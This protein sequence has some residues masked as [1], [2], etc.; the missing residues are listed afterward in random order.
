MRSRWALTWLLVVGL[1]PLAHGLEWSGIRDGALHLKP[2][3][4]EPLQ[5][6]WEP[7]WQ[8]D[9]NEE[10]L[11]L[12]DSTGKLLQ[13]FDIPAHEQRGTRRW[14]LH[15]ASSGYRLEIPGYSFRLYQIRHGDKTASLFEPV[16]THFSMEAGRDQTLYFR[17]PAGVSVQLGGKHHGGVHALTAER[18]SDKHQVHL[19]LQRHALYPRSDL[20]NLPVS[21]QEQIWRLRLLG[22]GKAAFWL[23]GTDNLF[24]QRPEHLYQPSQPPGRVGLALHNKVLGPTAKL[25][26]ALP[27]SLPEDATLLGTLRPQAAGHYSF[28]N[29]MARNP[30]H[31]QRFRPLFRHKYGIAN[32]ITLLAKTGRVADLDFDATSRAGLQ[33]WLD[34]TSRLGAG[35]T[36][37]LSMADEPN[38]NYS[39][40]SRF[41][42]Y[43]RAMA[44][45]VRAHP[46]AHA[47]GIRI[48]IPASSRLVNGPTM[49]DSRNRRGIDW[50]KRLLDEH[51]PL[52]DALAWHEWMV[53]DLRATDWYRYSVRQAADLVGLDEQGRPRKALLID[54]TNLSS[55]NTISHYEQDTQFAALWWASVAIQSS[56]DGLLD[57]LNWFLL[58][59]DDGHFKGM[60]RLDATG[61]YS[62]RPVGHAMNFMQRYWGDDVLLLDNDAFEV[63]ALASRSGKQLNLLG[64]NKVDRLQRVRFTHPNV[65][66]SGLDPPRLNLFSAI[67][68]VPG[69]VNCVSGAWQF[70]VPAESLFALTWEQP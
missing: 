59:D 46:D 2:A 35:G 69:A 13:R 28:V 27:Y 39:S 45:R 31:E 19:Q 25:G 40:Y 60:L 48:A 29:V 12:Q 6:A 26:V 34:S 5:I 24:A 15:T 65:T 62:L 55:G 23:D 67:P 63:D 50:A 4:D 17:V 9:G 52:I 53:R 47:A 57:M 11:Y 68:V 8:A 44:E 36:H 18:L 43:F 61:N 21:T 64:V 3:A 41:A 56:A 70:E 33:A 42:D 38:L 58:A 20:V 10:R 32:D 16:K 49:T 51:E 14:P 54:Q 66:C 7:A 30:Q 1:Q 22:K 37:F